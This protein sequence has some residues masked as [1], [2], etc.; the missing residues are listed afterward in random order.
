MSVV[1]TFLILAV[2]IIFL[3]VVFVFL[4]QL[5]QGAIQNIYSQIQ[6]IT[7]L[8]NETTKQLN[9]RLD[10][11]ISLL[12]TQMSQSL[13]HVINQVGQT[14]EQVNQRLDN[15]AK[16]MAELSRQIGAVQEG[17]NQIKNIGQSIS[18]LEDL[19]KAQQF[20]GKIGEFTLK[21]L[22]EDVL[23]PEF[24]EFQYPFKNGL[25]VDAIIKFQDRLLPID[26]KFPL[27]NYIKMREARDENERERIKRELI[28]NIKDR[29]K[30]ISEKYIRTDEKTFD[31]AMM[32][33]PSESVYY[34]LVSSEDSDEILKFMWEKR[35]IP[36][37]PSTFYAQLNAFMLGFKAI[38]VEKNI[39]NIIDLLSRLAGEFKL[40]TEDFQTLGRHINNVQSKYHEI[41]RKLSQFGIS[42]NQ[43][44]K[45][46]S[47]QRFD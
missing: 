21:K 34:E 8:V 31:F 44:T 18:K 19:F 3:A 9:Q 38:Q 7:N 28:K 14:T 26:S 6:L 43:V 11:T 2:V 5:F 13:T 45:Q 25:K 10:N 1:E 4:K 24:Y 30:E 32:Y 12:S 46:E 22:I 20:R 41:D 27:D 42:F 16:V 47:F 35:V 36:V 17:A 40:I 39:K 37:S 29:V 23:P 15:A 33:I